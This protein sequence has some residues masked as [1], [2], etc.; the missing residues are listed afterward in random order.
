MN[1]F[2]YRKLNGLQWPC[3]CIDKSCKWNKKRSILLHKPK[4]MDKM[5]FF[6]T[7]NWKCTKLEYS[8]QVQQ[9]IL[10]LARTKDFIYT[11]L[12]TSLNGNSWTIKHVYQ[13][14]L[15]RWLKVWKSW[16]P[17]TDFVSVTIW[18]QWTLVVFISYENTVLVQTFL[19]ADEYY[20]LNK[21]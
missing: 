17:C 7:H 3:N 21:G 18:E 10:G 4:Y 1:L 5:Y 12:V 16:S 19:L 20:N 2:V 8:T 13:M 9:M 11:V 15:K 6:S 14:L